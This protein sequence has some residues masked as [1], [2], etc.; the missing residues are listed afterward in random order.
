MGFVGTFLGLFD[1][2][3][4]VRNG[5]GKEVT[6]MSPAAW[7]VVIIVVLVAIGGYLWYAKKNS[8]WPFAHQKA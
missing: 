6:A 1:Y 8:K 5:F 4:R 3:H 7:I 2:P